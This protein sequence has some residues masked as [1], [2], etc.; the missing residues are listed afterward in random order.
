MNIQEAVQKAAEED[1]MIVREKFYQDYGE[2]AQGIP[3][4]KDLQRLY[5]RQRCELCGA[6][7]QR[8]NQR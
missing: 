2:H 3:Q 6:Y 5:G 8:D 7:N 4:G 1:K